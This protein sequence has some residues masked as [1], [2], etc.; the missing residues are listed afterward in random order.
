MGLFSTKKRQKPDTS[1]SKKDK[2]ISQIE[3]GLSKTWTGS[4][5]N[6]M[7]SFDDDENDWGS[8]GLER[9]GPSHEPKTPLRHSVRFSDYYECNSPVN[10]SAKENKSD[11]LIFNKRDLSTPI[12][13]KKIKMKGL[14]QKIFS[15]KKKKR[16]KFDNN[17]IK[18]GSIPGTEQNLEG[19]AQ[20]KQSTL[21]SSRKNP[22]R[23]TAIVSLSKTDQNDVEC[24]S[25]SDETEAIC[26]KKKNE[27][28]IRGILKHNPSY[29]SNRPEFCVTPQPSLASAPNAVRFEDEDTSDEDIENN[30]NHVNTEPRDE[31]IYHGIQTHPYQTPA[32]QNKSYLSPYNQDINQHFLPQC[33]PSEPRSPLANRKR[34]LRQIGTPDGG[35]CSSSNV[36]Q[37]IARTQTVLSSRIVV[38]IRKTMADCIAPSIPDSPLLD[39]AAL[40]EHSAIVPT[41]HAQSLKS[42]ILAP[43]A[44]SKPD[45]GWRPKKDN[46]EY[47]GAPRKKMDERPQLKRLDPFGT[48]SRKYNSNRSLDPI[49]PRKRKEYVLPEVHHNQHSPK[50]LKEHMFDHYLGDNDVNGAHH[51]N[52]FDNEDGVVDRYQIQQDTSP[53]TSSFDERPYFELPENNSLSEYSDHS[54]ISSRVHQV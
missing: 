19:K 7:N 40:P 45:L 32:T 24:M 38:A 4:T 22:N 23:K 2:N 41:V 52:S 10:D 3:K 9:R 31:I 34:N 6:E 21:F 11:D 26:N 25:S 13:P 46:D 36:T 43:C 47:I 50:R 30:L 35:I 1:S 37:I 29:S 51:R 8:M 17:Q 12:A 49:T 53:K 33:L 15:T 39:N 18:Q 5:D 16:N 28:P 27:T 42:P 48:T 54:R 44:P 14:R 20:S